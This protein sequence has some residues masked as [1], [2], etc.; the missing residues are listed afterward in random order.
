MSTIIVR[1]QTPVT[2]LLM[3]WTSKLFRKR[4]F[5]VLL[6]GFLAIQVLAGL[7][8]NRLMF[9][10]V[11]GGYNKSMSGFVDIG[12]NGV[13]I[14][15]RVLGPADGRKAIIYC[16]GN[17]ED[18]TVLDERFHG[19]IEKGVVVTSFDYPGYGLSSGTPDEKG[20]YEGAM[21]LYDWL[22]SE[23]G[24]HGEDIVVVGYSIGSGVATE[25]AMRRK[26]AGLWLES[27]FLSAPR[28]VTRKRLL[29][30][31]P[32]QNVSKLPTLKCPLMMLHGTSDCIVPYSQGAMLFSVSAQPKRFIAVAGAGHTD[33][34]ELVG[35]STY[36]DLLFCFVRDPAEAVRTEGR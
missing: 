9:H 16:H 6:I 25:L 11:I 32:F 14:A 13:K 36:A 22:V 23:R 27:A 18:L 21:R 3:A 10:P 20:C 1:S 31:D 28:A 26:I 15:A 5:I 12:T 33:V 29:L 34:Q 7:L 17:A 19:V 24:F 4:D 8:I 30:I 2:V 35:D